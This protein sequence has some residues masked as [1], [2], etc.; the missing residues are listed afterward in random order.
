MEMEFVLFRFSNSR[1]V[2]SSKSRDKSASSV[3]S[4]LSPSP[5]ASG[6]SGPG[7]AQVSISGKL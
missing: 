7:G 6:L 4:A 2:D 5:G 1:I 3:V